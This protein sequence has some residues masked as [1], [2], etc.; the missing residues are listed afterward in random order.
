MV[1][2]PRA[3]RP[4]TRLVDGL[5]RAYLPHPDAVGVLSPAVTF[6]PPPDDDV[7]S[8]TAATD[9]RHAYCTTLDAALCVT[10]DGTLLWRSPFE[11]PANEVFGHR[12]GC[13]LSTD[14]Q[15]LWVYRPDAMAGRGRPDQWIALDA[16]TGEVLARADLETV[17][18]G[19][20]QLAHPAGAQML[21]N[22]GEGQDGSVVHRA[23]VTGGRIELV[24]Y[25]WDDRCLIDLSPDGHRFLTVDHAQNDLAVH[26]F[27]GGEV[28]FTLTAADFGH[29]PDTVFLEWSGGHLTEDTLLATLVGQD[30]DEEDWFRHYLLDARTGHVHGEF[31]TRTTDPYDLHPLG[32]GSWLTTGPGGHPVRHTDSP[33]PGATS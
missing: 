5:V 31:D 21:L 16:A 4:V 8:H 33:Y 32:D 20:V 19:G 10:A 11:P 30:E 1:S 2:S 6:R 9:L 15:V 28:L 7:V 13:E 29:D 26:A 18:H 24:T 23:S 14:G 25:P 22:V 12:P 27:P 3:V 17:G